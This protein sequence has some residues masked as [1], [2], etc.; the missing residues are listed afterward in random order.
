MKNIFNICIIEKVVKILRLTPYPAY[1]IGTYTNRHR[2]LM[3]CVVSFG[4]DLQR[5]TEKKSSLLQMRSKP[6]TIVFT[7]KYYA[8]M[9]SS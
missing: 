6:K 2:F 1:T 5:A 4:D 8:V 7:V 9:V 3:G